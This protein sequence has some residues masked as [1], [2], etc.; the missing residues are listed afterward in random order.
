MVF[1]LSLFAYRDS[2]IL[3]LGRS[4]TFW[5]PIHADEYIPARF[6]LIPP[7]P[8][9]SALVAG[10]DLSIARVLFSCANSKVYPPVVQRVAVYMVYN[11]T[12]WVS[13][14]LPVEREALSAGQVPLN[15]SPGR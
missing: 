7:K 12:R 2:D 5:L 14:Y 11:Q 1:F 15:V 13:H 10:V 6:F 3:V 8:D 4:E 9:M